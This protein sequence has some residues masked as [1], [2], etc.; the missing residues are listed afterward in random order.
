MM[1][2]LADQ[3]RDPDFAKEKNRPIDLSTRIEMAS[4]LFCFL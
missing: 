2:V 1:P 3:G 4:Q